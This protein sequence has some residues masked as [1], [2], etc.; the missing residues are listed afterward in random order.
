MQERQE[1]CLGKPKDINADGLISQTYYGRTMPLTLPVAYSDKNFY[2]TASIDGSG[3][4]G[5]SYDHCHI[6]NTNTLEYPRY[7]ENI[8]THIYTEGY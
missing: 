8:K 6:V 5:N 7:V 4:S 2:A 3:T 1:L